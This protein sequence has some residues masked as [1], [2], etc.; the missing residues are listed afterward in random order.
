MTEEQ[1]PRKGFWEQAREARHNSDGWIKYFI[2]MATISSV[3]ACGTCLMVIA[4]LIPFIA[5]IVGI[6][7][8][9]ECPVNSMIPVYLIAVGIIGVIS[10]SLGLWRQCA[11]DNVKTLRCIACLQI[12]LT[13]FWFGF[14]IAGNIWVYGA[15]KKVETDEEKRMLRPAGKEPVPNPNY[16]NAWVFWL[17]FFMITMVYVMVV[18]MCCLLCAL[19]AIV[20]RSKDE[21]RGPI[22]TE[23]ENPNYTEGGESPTGH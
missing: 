10:S 1:A 11:G 7:K 8:F 16:C 20:A 23:N 17:A 22:M 18:L 6:A 13:L 15:L 14:F 3:T 5:V 4:L 21:E 12:P 9:N 2:T 19:G